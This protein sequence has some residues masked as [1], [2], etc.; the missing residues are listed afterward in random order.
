MYT[1]CV[2]FAW[3]TIKGNIFGHAKAIIYIKHAY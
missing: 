1:I 3:A 2:H